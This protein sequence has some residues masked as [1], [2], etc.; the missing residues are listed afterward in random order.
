MGIILCILL[1]LFVNGLVADHNARSIK[2]QR[3]LT[4]LRLRIENPT[5]YA[6]FKAEE[7]RK[8][9][10]E[11]RAFWLEVL[12]VLMLIPIIHMAFIHHWFGL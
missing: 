5:G 10:V 7:A 8:R 11:D 4:L 3:E 6:Q 2:A 12:G 9:R 1:I